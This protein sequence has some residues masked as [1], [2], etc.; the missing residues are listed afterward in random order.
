M[1]TVANC[2]TD[3]TPTTL[4]DTADLQ[5]VLDAIDETARLLVSL[6]WR[7]QRIARAFDVNDCPEHALIEGDEIPTFAHIGEL[8]A[9]VLEARLRLTDE[10][11]H[12]LETIE[13]K[14]RD[15]DTIR[16]MY[17]VGGES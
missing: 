7:V 1:A 12:Y 11:L 5:A 8:Y 16:L 3:Q 17:E 15:L 6:Q 2:D 14:L 13:D 9:F 4:P 10:P